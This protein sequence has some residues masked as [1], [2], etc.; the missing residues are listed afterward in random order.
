MHSPFLLYS[1]RTMLVTDM[2]FHQYLETMVLISW[3][4]LVLISEYSQT[5]HYGI[6]KCFD[7]LGTYIDFTCQP[8]NN[9]RVIRVGDTRLTTFVSHSAPYIFMGSTIKFSRVEPFQVLNYHKFLL[10]FSELSH[11]FASET[12]SCKNLSA[13]FHSSR[14]LNRRKINSL[15]F[16]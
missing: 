16:P 10:M 13:E 6:E 2:W 12:Q 8:F 4:L 14:S 9:I 11:Q 3:N 15:S 5:L 7:I 1:K